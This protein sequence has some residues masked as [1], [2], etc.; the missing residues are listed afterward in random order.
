MV[1]KPTG[2]WIEKKADARSSLDPWQPLEGAGIRYM[3]TMDPDA[4]DWRGEV[5]IPWKAL[6]DPAKGRPRLLRFNF[7]QHRNDTGESSTWAGPVD[8]GRDD[9]FTGV[10]VLRDE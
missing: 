1:C 2:H 5:A 9:A 10:L 7:T 3:A 4:G 8:F 6:A